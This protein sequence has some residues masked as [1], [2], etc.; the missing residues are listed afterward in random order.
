MHTSP[1]CHSVVGQRPLLVD[2]QKMCGL[3]VTRPGCNVRLLKDRTNFSK[4]KVLFPIFHLDGPPSWSMNVV[5][6]CPSCRGRCSSNDGET[7][8][9]L[10]ARAASAH[11]VKSKHALQN[12]SCHIGRSTTDVF[13]ALMTT[14]DNG[15]FCS[16]LL[17]NATNRSHLE[18]VSN[19]CSFLA[20][21][22]S[23]V[24]QECLRK[25]GD[26]LRTR[27]TSLRAATM[28]LGL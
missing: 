25:N 18:R 10:P 1:R 4:N 20:K 5:M 22:K 17:C 15:D 8:V 28:H 26:C 27:A 11:P 2:W 13:D 24:T 12:R 16:R 19:C 3:H 14:H 21:N 9:Q 7:L 6:M 23:C